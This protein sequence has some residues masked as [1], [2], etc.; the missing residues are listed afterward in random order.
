MSKNNQDHFF[1]RNLTNHSTINQL[2]N[3]IRC[4][5]CNKYNYLAYSSK[6]FVCI[7][8]NN[9]ILVYKKNKT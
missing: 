3:I 8:C 1:H 5:K 9:P 7:F 6:A 4:K 2:P